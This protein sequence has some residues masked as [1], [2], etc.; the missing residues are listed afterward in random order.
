MLPVQAALLVLPSALRVMLIPISLNG[1]GL[2]EGA[3]AL[4][5]PMVG[6][7]AEVSVAARVIFGLAVA[8][9]ALIGAVP[10]MI[11]P[12]PATALDSLQ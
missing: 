6:V 4:L 7:A 11:R 5:W 2:R 12:R 1:W 9:A 8:F 3:A 10:V